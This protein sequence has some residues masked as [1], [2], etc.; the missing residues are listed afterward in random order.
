[1]KIPKYVHVGKSKILNFP[2]FLE[3]LPV[4]KHFLPEAGGSPGTGPEGAG[5]R[6]ST[7]PCRLPSRAPSV[8]SAEVA[9]KHYPESRPSLTQLIPGLI[10]YPSGN[11]GHPL[12]SLL[13]ESKKN[14]QTVLSYHVAVAQV[15]ISQ[16]H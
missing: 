1:M 16:R 4:P 9:L 12:P 13:L 11:L 10:P 14:V 2:D 8:C 5:S 3:L 7:Q 6:A 15:R